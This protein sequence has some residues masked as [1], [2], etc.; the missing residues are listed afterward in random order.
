MTYKVVI[1]GELVSTKETFDVLNPA[2]E[3]ATGKAPHCTEV[4]C[5][6]AVK[7][8]QK[9]FPG[10][11]DTDIAKR[12]QCLESAMDVLKKNSDVIATLLCQ[13]QGK[14]KGGENE[15]RAFVGASGEMAFCNSI[16]NRAL[17]L[18]P[19]DDVTLDSENHKCT[20]YRKP[21][22]AVAGLYLLFNFIFTNNP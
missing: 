20:V 13:E 5:D 18:S 12:K 17:S 15:Q 11:R 14:P 10:W 1:N 7:A 16:V 2:T 6:A 4:E 3:S 19:S 22:G 8:A 9:A 21:I